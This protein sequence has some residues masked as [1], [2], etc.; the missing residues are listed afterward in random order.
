[1]NLIFDRLG[2]FDTADWP[3]ERKNLL[4]NENNRICIPLRKNESYSKDKF[5]EVFKTFFS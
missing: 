2:A 5:F 1:M 4:C 3:F